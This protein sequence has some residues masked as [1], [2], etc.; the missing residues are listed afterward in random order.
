[1]SRSGIAVALV[2]IAATSAAAQTPAERAART[3]QR[4]ADDA[5]ATAPRDGPPRALLQC[6]GFTSAGKPTQHSI[7]IYTKYATMDEIFAD[8]SGDDI[9][10]AV[11]G[12]AMMK[13]MG[14]P[15]SWE[16][17]INRLTGAYVVQNNPTLDSRDQVE[18][19]TCA[20]VSAKF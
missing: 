7:A 9:F 11:T 8:I 19:G 17:D 6:A 14:V 5:A 4:A 20:K 13:D 3:A 16:F 2:L 12:P 15:P 1:M 10:Y 18:T